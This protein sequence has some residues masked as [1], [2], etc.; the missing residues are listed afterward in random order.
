MGMARS[1]RIAVNAAGGDLRAPT[2]LYGIIDADYYRSVWD[3][4]VDDQ[5]QKPACHDKTAPAGAVQ[6]LVITGEVGGSGTTCDAERRAHR[7]L[8]GRKYCPHQ[9]YQRMLKN[10]R[11][12]KRAERGHPCPNTIW[13]MITD[14][15]N[16]GA[17]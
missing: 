12:E 2:P 16:M 10:R 4:V 13:D 15:Q 5:R 3:E 14:R 9:Q 8:T 11:R 17:K 1:D 6:D 7:A